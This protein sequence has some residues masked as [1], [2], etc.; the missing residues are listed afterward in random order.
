M[1]RFNAESAGNVQP[2]RLM[3]VLKETCVPDD[4]IRV[5]ADKQGEVKSMHRPANN[6]QLCFIQYADP[7]TAARAIEE[8]RSFPLF[9]AVDPALK[10]ERYQENHPNDQNQK[11]QQNKQFNQNRNEGRN[12]NNFRRNDG[13]FNNRNGDIDSPP[14]Q[15]PMETQQEVPLGCWYC[16]KMP[17]FECQCGAFY[18]DTGCQRAD[19]PK[20]KD[21]CMSRMVPISFSNK[22][23]LQQAVASRNASTI[24]ST[25][26]TPSSP[27]YS[28]NNNNNQQQQR[29]QPQQNRFNGNDYNQ[30]Q[31]QQQQYGQRNNQQQNVQ[32]RLANGQRQNSQQ[33]GSDQQVNEAAT[34][35]QRMKLNKAGSSS[36]PGRKQILEPGRFPPEGARVKITT[37]LQSGCLYIYHNNGGQHGGQSD[38]QALIN[39]LHQAADN[40]SRPL[41]GAP[42]VDDV[43]FAP[44]QGMFYRAK[45]L[46][47]K[48]TKIDVQFP[49]FGNLE[50]VALKECREIL[51]EELKWAK[52]LS[53]PVMLDGVEGPLTKEQK[54]MVEQLEFEEEFELVAAET[55]PDSEVRQVVLKRERQNVT[56][57]MALV[58]LKEK[59]ARQRRL[60]EEQ[61][62]A[63][64][65]LEKAEKKKQELAAKIPDPDTYKPL[66]FDEVATAKQL[67]ADK[68]YTLCIIDAS[69]VLESKLISVIAAEH[70]P[71]YGEVVADCERFGLADPNEYLPKMQGELCLG[72]YKADWSRVL[73]DDEENSLL[74]DVGTLVTPDEFRRFPAGL[75]CTVYNNEVFVENMPLLE[76]MMKDGKPKSIHGN[77]VDAWVAVSDNGSLGIRIIPKAN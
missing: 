62:A 71:Q 67:T 45:V 30:Q 38:F 53:F 22:M 20:H 9:K 15:A 68:R 56:L 61:R 3:I 51:N 2:G 6:Q 36:S 50:T 33:N 49:D 7:D 43:V 25:P 54:H 73:Y 40:E 48:E 37:S 47:V 10:S 11:K 63:K 8:L 14:R 66:I 23:I 75:S 72:R 69:E 24:S 5:I 39:R 35:L 32:N 58:E 55:V 44:Y 64:E 77:T 21:N 29:Q 52:Y 26:Y 16:A 19:W 76:Q 12:S 42:K 31:Q 4:V 27:E 74:L 46:A 17:N 59:E 1:P 65:R 70:A 18:C 28:G 13:G 57:N 41:A 34:K 60:R